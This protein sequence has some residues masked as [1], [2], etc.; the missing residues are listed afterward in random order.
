MVR[1]AEIWVTWP[2]GCLSSAAALICAS[3]DRFS[4]SAPTPLLCRQ[5]PPS[6]HIEIGQRGAHLQ[7]VQVLR[8][9]PIA[10]LLKAKHP[11]DDADGV[12]NLGPNPGLGPIPRLDPFIDPLAPAVTLVGEIPCSRCRRT[13]RISLA[14]IGLI[15]PD[16]CLLAM[17]QVRQR[18]CICRV[19]RRGQNRVDQLALAV[20]PHV[21]L[22]PEIPLLA[23]AYLV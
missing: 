20:H 1:S 17:Q 13:Y 11:L 9:S 19:R 15:A 5:Q 18:Q 16:T 4:R 12:L 14:A 21:H 3:P 22:H 6:D 2:K 7:P 8:Q 10:N 23:F